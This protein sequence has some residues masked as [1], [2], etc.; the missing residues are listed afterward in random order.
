MLMHQNNLFDFLIMVNLDFPRKNS[1][2]TSIAGLESN[3][4]A[5]RPPQEGEKLVTSPF[6]RSKLFSL[7]KFITKQFPLLMH[8]TF[9]VDSEVFLI[10]K[11][12]GF[13]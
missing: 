5:A 6:T 2:I 3:R 12:A 10:I 4:K 7:K 8:E 13:T 9:L 11:A 1:F